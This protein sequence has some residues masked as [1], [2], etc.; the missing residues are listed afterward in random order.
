MGRRRA[1]GAEISM[2]KER[3]KIMY[4]FGQLCCVGYLCYL[5]V[6]DIQKRRLPEGLLAAG[7]GIAA[8]VAALRIFWGFGPFLLGLAGAAVGGGFLWISKV[9]D[10][11]FGYGD[12]ILIIALGLFLGL[13]KLLYLL[14]AA[15]GLS[16]IFSMVMMKRQ[17]FQRTTTMPFVPFFGAAYVVLLL[18]R[19]F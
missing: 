16:A 2:I 17:N 18:A 10:E 6:L 11:A 15:F 19:L 1:A 8:G 5:S 9:T 12:S 13:W 14:M 7:V 4:S 3:R